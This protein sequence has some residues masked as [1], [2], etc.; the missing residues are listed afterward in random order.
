MMMF[1]SFWHTIFNG[2]SIA[3]PVAE[4]LAAEMRSRTIFATH[5]HELKLEWILSTT[6]NP[7]QAMI[8]I[9]CK[10]SLKIAAKY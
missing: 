2:L 1:I 4:Y 6:Y 5:Y 3:W 9:T 8:F 10:Y 7:G